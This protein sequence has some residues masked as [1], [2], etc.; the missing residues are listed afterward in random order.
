MNLIAMKILIISVMAMCLLN[1][2]G[3]YSEAPK[4]TSDVSFYVGTYTNLESKGIYRYLLQKDGTLKNAG[5][6]AKADNPSFLAKSP[7]HKFLVAV[8]EMSNANGV[9]YVTSYD[10][11]GDRLKLIN[12]Q[13]SGGSY[14][15]FVTID[16]M[17]YVMTANYGDGTIGL[18]KLNEEGE[19]S[20][21]L[22]LQHHVG[23]GTTPRQ[24]GPHAHSVWPGTI[25]APIITVDL[26]T[27]E[28]W[29]SLIDPNKQKMVP[30]PPYKLAMPSGAGPRHMAFYPKGPWAYVLNE[31]SST[32]TQ[33]EKTAPLKYAVGAS[34]ATLPVDYHGENSAADIH[35][36]SD[37]KFL[38]AS[39]RGHDSIVIYKVSPI[40]GTL[41][42]VGYESTHG[43][44]PRNFSL[45]PD[46]N[47]LV[48]A[49]QETNT[50]VSFRRDRNKGTL[51]FKDQVAAPSPVCI[52]F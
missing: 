1:V 4:A 26:G 15:C 33:I 43:K 17:G 23:N 3:P 42:L 52:L 18:L 22:D 13:S 8:N 40:D 28:L 24:E 39:N 35:I 51:K 44:T 47:F 45:S 48:V 19:L 16:S 49:N 27:N 10:I 31:L 2:K 37:G 25:G 32:V 11:E 34:V 9:G 50:I 14:P 29:F 7:S 21:L 30:T 5:L 12:Q 20:D 38:Y 6:I 41:T 36:S 46:E